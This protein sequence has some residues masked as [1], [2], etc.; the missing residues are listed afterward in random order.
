MAH[1]FSSSTATCGL[2]A[3]RYLPRCFV[4]MRLGGASTGGTSTGGLRALVR[5]NCENVR[6]NWENGFFC[7]LPMMLPKYLYKVLGYFLKRGENR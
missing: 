1:P 7:C 3:A 4:V 2:C 5:L 6:A